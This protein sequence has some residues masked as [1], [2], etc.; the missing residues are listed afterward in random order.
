MTVAFTLNGTA[1]E[2]EGD[3]TMPLLWFVRERQSLTGAIG[4]R[5][6]V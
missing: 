2:H 5:V 1:V 6:P 3:P 4:E